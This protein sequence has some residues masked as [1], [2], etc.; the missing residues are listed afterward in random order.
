MDAKLTVESSMSN[1]I[2]LRQLIESILVS[3]KIKKCVSN[4]VIL[5]CEEI[6]SNICSYAYKNIGSVSFKIYCCDKFIKISF[7]DNGVEFDPTKSDHYKSVEKIKNRI[8]GG[9]GIF[10]AKQNMNSIEYLRRNNENVLYMTKN[11]GSDDF[12]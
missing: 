3:N 1:W 4:K 12:E 8:P 5:S 10:I 7:I 2:L 9:L 11:L 6:F